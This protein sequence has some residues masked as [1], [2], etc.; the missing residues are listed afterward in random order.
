MDPNNIRMAVIGTGVMGTN[1]LKNYIS[2]PNVTLAGIYDI[3]CSR[4]E[5]KA[6][7]FNTTAYT[8]LN[9]LIKN[10][11][12]A[13]IVTPTSTHFS[14][15]KTILAAGIPCL[16]EKPL[17][18]TK[19]DCEELIE[20][21]KNNHT[22]FIVGHIERFNPAVLKLTT[23]LQEKKPKIKSIAA[24]R[25][26]EASGRISDVAV[27]SDL[28]IH[29]LDIII[30]LIDSKITSLNVTGDKDDATVNITFA[31]GAKGK[32]TASRKVKGKV[33]TLNLDTSIGIFHLN[34][35]EQTL[36]LNNQNIPIKKSFS[37]A[38]ELKHF[39][40]CIQ[41]KENPII[42]GEIALNALNV[43]WNI[44]KQLPF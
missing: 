38:E 15:G 9:E 34:Y 2:M 19:K 17:A 44:E 27:T 16:I 1:H 12:A 13:S 33:R 29:D 36:S 25:I 23:I 26:N 11:D 43:M 18:T 40:A 4:A 30:S 31:N 7:E 32:L 8:D 39:I 6:A 37:L 28:M 41:K 21:A 14:T 10:I 3:D 20:T 24:T 22:F 5:A 35:V 42:T